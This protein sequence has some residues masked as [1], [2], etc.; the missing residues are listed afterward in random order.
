M[1]DIVSVGDWVYSR[2]QIVGDLHHPASLLDPRKATFCLRFLPH[3]HT[4]V[5]VMQHTV[6]TRPRVHV[7]HSTHVL[8]ENGIVAC[9][10]ARASI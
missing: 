2:K 10:L 8:L 4:F 6:I 9:V 3:A 1:G 7:C 5:N